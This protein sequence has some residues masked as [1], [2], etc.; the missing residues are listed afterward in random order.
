MHI[1]TVQRIRSQYGELA[2]EKAD[3]IL[4]ATVIRCLSEASELCRQS[5]NC[6]VTLT[7]RP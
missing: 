2:N 5:I 3:L 7:K 6:A 4:L 1:F